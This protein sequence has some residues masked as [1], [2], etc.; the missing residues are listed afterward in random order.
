MKEAIATGAPQIVIEE[1]HDLLQ[2]HISTYFNNTNP[3][4]PKAQHRHGKPLKSLFERIVGKEG[5]IRYN[6]LGK[7]VNFSARA[8]ISPDPKI[9]INEVGVPIEVAKILTVPHRVTKHNI[10]WLRKFVLNGPNKYPGANYVISPDGKRRAIYEENKEQL[11]SMLEP[12][13][14]VER[15][16]I[17]GD[18]VLFGRY[19]SLHRLS[20]MGHYVK[21]LP[22]KTFRLH[23]AVCP[24]YNAD[25]DG[26]EMNIHVPQTEEA[27]AEAKLLTTVE[28]HIIHVKNGLLIVGGNQE[29]VTGLYL[30]S[31]ENTK[32]PISIAT[33]LIYK[34]NP[35]ENEL[36]KLERFIERA[37]KE[38][39]DYLTGREV[40]SVL[41]PDDL[42]LKVGNVI[43]EKGELKQ[44]ILDSKMIKAEKGELIVRI[45]N[46]YGKDYTKEFIY[47]ISL[48]G[49]YYQY[50]VG[51]TMSLSDFDLKQEAR[52]KIKEVIK[53]AEKNV[54]ELYNKYKEDKLELIVGKTKKETFEYYVLQEISKATTNIMKIIRE[55]LRKDTGT[56]IMADSGARG[57]MDDVVAMIGTLGAQAF[58]GRLIEF[59]YKDRNLTIFKRGDI[60][61]ITKGWVI[62]S[63][64][65]GLKPWEFFF[66]AI[67]GRDALMDTAIRTSRSGYLHR[68]MMHSLYEVFVH[69]DLSVRDNYGRII[70][71]LW[72]DDGIAVNKSDAGKIDIKAIIDY[73]LS[74][75]N[76]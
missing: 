10:E 49:I 21:V 53:E 41:L 32:V 20:L 67:P 46:I 37:K 71:F 22:G 16:L 48:L 24:P 40:I 2:Y 13:W 44:G 51:I 8:V 39:R 5:R 65:D 23:P 7:R 68:R 29:I 4:L 76:L 47:K 3:H 12:G 74:K 25:F 50:Y 70:Q 73:V 26:D 60:H 28:N 66:H 19:P 45:H 57:K 59:G 9:K 33:D 75:Y 18:I 64:Y 69:E 35:N 17:D 43:I 72:G 30:L 27:I 56:F 52:E 38:G 55:S 36:R 58:R 14:I 42:S 34:T 63:Y 15:H 31:Q 1:L 6:L 11:A 54:Q 61:P 62:S